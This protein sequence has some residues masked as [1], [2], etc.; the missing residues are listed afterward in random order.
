[1]LIS[2]LK[3][4]TIGVFF[5]LSV[6]FG[7][8]H[9]TLYLG[10]ELFFYHGCTEHLKSGACNTIGGTKYVLVDFF[11]GEEKYMIFDAIKTLIADGYIPI[12]AHVERYR[13][14]NSHH[15]EDVSALKAAGALIQVNAPSV[16]GANGL[17]QKLIARDIIRC[18]MCDIVCSDAHD[19][20]ARAHYMSK[21]YA[22][23]LKKHGT[24]LAQKLTKDN[25]D[26]LLL[27]QRLR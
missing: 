27:G 8:Q 2:I 6:Q 13:R 16:I 22:Y 1:M 7:A 24:E 25:A 26:T 19:D 9:I 23:I 10:N 11:S 15:L 3:F 21:A 17:R 4:Y 5:V 12:I 14:L 18:G 20:S